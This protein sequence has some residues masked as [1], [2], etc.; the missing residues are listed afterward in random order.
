MHQ[1]SLLLLCLLS[2]N[3]T[4]VSVMTLDFTC[5]GEAETLL[6]SG[7]CLYF[8]HCFL[9]LIV[10]ISGGNA[11]T[12]RYAPYFFTMGGTDDVMLVRRPTSICSANPHHPWH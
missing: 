9:F 5:S 6:G 3:V 4:V 1:V 8:W 11:Y 2:Q 10:I 7:V 12:G